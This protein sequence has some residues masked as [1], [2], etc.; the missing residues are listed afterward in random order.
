MDI[1][2]N[3][4]K[5]I[6]D[7][8]ND[9][10]TK[11]TLRE[12]AAQLTC[13]IVIS[14]S[15][16]AKQMEETLSDGIG[17]ISYLSLS[18]TGDNQKDIN[19]LKETQ[20]FL[21]EKTRLGIPALA[22]SEGIAGA[23]IPG[24][25]T[26]PQSLGLAATWEPELA[27]KM[28]EV[29]KKQ[30]KAYGIKAVHSPLFDLG[31][32]PRWGRIGETYGEDPY[33]VAQMGSA[34]VRGVQGKNE[35]MATAKHFVAFGNTEGGRNGGEQQIGERK[36][37]DV[38]CFPFEAAIHEGKIMAIMNSYGIVNEEPVAASE[39]LLTE[40]LRN[41]LGFRGPLVAD[42]GSISHEYN[43]Y[44]TASNP[45]DA[46][47]KSL[48]AGI[49]VDQ[50][51]NV[52]YRHLVDAVEK[53]EIEEAYIDRALRRF[54]KVKFYL[55]L[56]ENPYGEGDFIAEIKKKENSE[57]S[58]EI[59]E[60]SIVLVK[61]ENNM[62]PL[63]KSKQPLK[64]ALIGPA[65]DNKANFF[66][67]YSSVGTV[68]ATS[69]DF[70]KSEE[71]N[72]IKTVYAALTTDYKDSLRTLGIVFDD[73]PSPE[74]KE[75]ILAHIR[76]DIMSQSNKSYKNTDEFISQYYPSC[77]SVKEAL[78]DEFGREYVFFAPGC[79][80]NTY[81]EDGI[82]AASETVKEADMVIA[83][84]G[85]R[86][87]M[88]AVEA[89]AGEN[90]D[91]TNVDLEKPQR[92]LMDA[93]FKLGKPVVSIIIDGRPLAAAALSEKSK[94]MLYAWLPA[95][96]GAQAIVNIIMGK[97]SPGGKLPVTIVKDSGQ[98]PMYY[99][100]LPFY[101]DLETRAEYIDTAKNTP[102][103]PFGH[104]LS[105]TAFNYGDLVIPRTAPSDGK[106]AVSF[107]VTNTGDVPGEETAQV[108]VRDCESSVGRPVKQLVGFA[109]ANFEVGE[110]KKIIIEINIR[111]F[112][113]HDSEMKQVVEPGKMEIYIGSSSEDIRLKGEFE[114]TGKKLI[115]E[116]KAFFARVTIE[117]R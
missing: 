97:R 92:D 28:G 117:E 106:I 22:H 44:R 114:I 18:L 105:Y 50:P 83:V 42:Y 79:G 75:R 76:Q 5:S 77:K 104:G 58:C 113:F 45:R 47:I 103:Y 82:E 13:T 1:Y 24:A 40:V 85:G 4:D 34:F 57:L 2:K 116:R 3:P 41:K 54:L 15:D 61:N 23:Q 38:F 115:V 73:Q 48:K 110:T 78:E 62:L 6:E 27:R 64:I 52:V 63:V 66:G 60:K 67:G 80:I 36:L 16:A 14:G 65:A 69:H 96:E 81:I 109:K 107:F 95:Q 68:S 32:D 51:K 91:N 101:A 70:D 89:T 84:L 26:F 21:V 37:L 31:R 30:I 19:T 86:E 87:S 111:Q 35:V 39:F 53:G 10:I 33:L 17:T 93:V 43:R 20:R 7:R 71:D 94:A 55:G 72:Y 25:T 98:I 108:Y 11:M 46:A 102:L 59:A 8:V 112:A 49:D 99:S 90:K 100:R 88:Q 74:Q 12:K 9:L 56:F 29:V